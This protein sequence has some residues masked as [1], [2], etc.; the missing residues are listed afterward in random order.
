MRCPLCGTK[1][2][3]VYTNRS[4]MEA[5]EPRYFECPKHGHITRSDLD[6]D[7]RRMDR[8]RRKR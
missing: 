7:E 6:R 2:T 3:A 4:E 5:G 8:A 1:L